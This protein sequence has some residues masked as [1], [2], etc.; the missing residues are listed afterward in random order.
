VREF[1]KAHGDPPVILVAVQKGPM[2]IAPPAWPPVVGAI[3]L[4]SMIL[5]RDVWLA[6]ANDWGKRYEGDGDMAIALHRAGHEAKYCPIMFL[7]GGQSHG[8]PEVAA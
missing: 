6:H 1:A 7:R 5:R 4:G 2:V 3:D 8:V